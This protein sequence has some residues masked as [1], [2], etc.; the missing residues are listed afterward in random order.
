MS[1][2]HKFFILRQQILYPSER[3][4][5]LII[6]MNTYALREAQGIW[7]ALT[8]QALLL[9]VPENAKFKVAVSEACAP[10]ST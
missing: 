6:I 3:F 1:R 7:V 8:S 9:D 10:I 2:N 5:L 4:L